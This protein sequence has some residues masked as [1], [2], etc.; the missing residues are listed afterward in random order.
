MLIVG[1]PRSGKTSL[2]YKLLDQ[3]KK[4]PEEDKTTRGIDIEQLEFDITDK[5]GKPRKLK[6]NV[7]DFGGQQIY[8]STHQFFLSH[9][10]LYVLVM[11]AGKDS[12][13]SED[14]TINYW[15]QVV[16]LLGGNSPLLMVMNEKNDRKVNLDLA[17]KRSRFNFLKG[18]FPVNLN[19]LIPKTL[20]FKKSRQ[21]EFNRLREEIELKLKHLPLVGFAMP[22][23][24]VKIREELQKIGKK[25][26]YISTLKYINICK[27]HK[28]S[29]FERQMELSRIFHDL[30]V[31]L[32]FQDK[33]A[34]ENLIILQNTWATDAVFAVLDNEKVKNNYGKFTNADMKTIWGNKG[35]S[36]DVHRQLLALMMEFELCYKVDHYSPVTYIVPEMLVNEVPQN[37]SWNTT[38]ELPLR[39]TYDFMPKGVLTRLIVRM[40]SHI[41]CDEKQQ[42]V[43]KS[44]MKIDGRDLDC[45]DTYA[46]ITEAWDNKQLSVLTQGTFRKDLMN[47]ISYEIDNLNKEYFRKSGD[48]NT[49]RSRWYKMIPCNCSKCSTIS[50]KHFHW[51]DNLLEAIKANS[52]I[53]CPKSFKM[54]KVRS[55]LD[56]VFGKEDRNESAKT[57]K[58]IFISYSHLDEL[59]Y[60]DV[61]CKHLS[62]LRSQGLIDDWT[63]R[64]IEA[65]DW[66]E[67]IE[68]A[69]K[70]ADIFLLLITHNFLSSQYI[71]TKEVITAYNRYKDGEAS[72]IPVICDSC[73]WQLHPISNTEME[74]NSNEG[75]AMKVWLGKLKALPKDA[76]PIKNWKN[77]QDGFLDVIEYLKKHLQ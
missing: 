71:T 30:G 11:D 59:E 67:Q 25:T 77:P 57:A 9:R 23:N 14:P 19:A 40:N 47:K 15:L 13:G 31:F 44:G 74:Y 72:I 6:Y 56:G 60:K 20:L 46:E 36:S 38:N 3:T 53:Q 52:D 1:Q 8:Q 73:L 28:V 33:D 75:R 27:K 54:V 45:P 43:W 29:D 49:Q 62:S 48:E 39:Y 17:S 76:K 61:M 32:H 18:D 58:K 42:W 22:K 69:A 51:Y 41:S 70:H 5:E 21:D 66:N 37:Y 64:Q 2:R 55:L 68:A 4:L 35:Y 26:P 10:S 65:G 7:W 12:T 63:D 16:E 50:D 34:L 24:W